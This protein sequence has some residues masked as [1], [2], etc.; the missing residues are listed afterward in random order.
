MLDLGPLPAQERPE[1]ALPPISDRA[2]DPYL[3]RRDFPILQ[4]QVHGRPLVWL[5]NAA[6]TQKP[7][8]VI[9]RLSYFYEHENSNIHR[10]AH[11]LAARSTDAYEAAREKVA[12]LPQRAVRDSIVFVRGTT[13]AINLVARAWGRRNVSEGDEIVITWL[14]HHANIV[15]WQLLCPR[16]ARR[17]A[18]RRSTTAAMISR[19]VREAARPA[20]AL[21]VVHPGLERA[22]HD[23]AGARDGRDG[24]SPR[25]PRAGRRRPGRLATCRSTCRRSA[26]D[27][28]VFSGHKV[29]APTGIGVL[30]GKPEVLEAMP[31]W[32][33]GGNMIED[34]TFE[35]TTYQAPP[36]IRGRHRQHRRCGRPRRRARLLERIGMDNIAA[37]EHEL[38]VYATEGLAHRARSDADRHAPRRRPACSR[39]CSTA[40]APR[41]SARPLTQRASRCARPSLRPADPA[42]LRL[43]GH[44]AAVARPL[45][46][47]RGRRR[48]RRRPAPPAGR[49]GQAG[50]LRPQGACT[51]AGGTLL[52]WAAA[53]AGFC[54]PAI[55]CAIQITQCRTNADREAPGDRPRHGR[56]SAARPSPQC[57]ERQY[58]RA[59]ADDPLH[60]CRWLAGAGRKKL[61]WARARPGSTFAQR[62]VYGRFIAELV[63]PHLGPP[64]EPGP[65]QVAYGEGRGIVVPPLPARASR[66]MTADASQATF[67]CLPPAMTRRRAAVPAC[68]V[69]P[70]QKSSTASGIDPERRVLIRGTGLTIVRFRR[71]TSSRG[72]SRAECTAMSRQQDFCRRRTA[73]SPP[74]RSIRATS[75]SARAS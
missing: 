44:R 18:S 35:K 22:R 51:G 11:T 46:H 13:E 24:A 19:G 67:R 36:D 71:V 66:S 33:G 57:A 10:A 75:R 32:Q 34:V 59:F 49:A 63:A 23:H 6:T 56:G 45:Q 39:S 43:R 1:L 4:E 17:C 73:P 12:P 74:S 38:L 54:S 28:Y 25:R 15:P 55:F 14:E 52:S 9:D 58:E 53:R 29:F 40:S 64:G 20:D 3:F 60:F 41:M 70:R 7:Q 68:Y 50:L 72:T 31:P 30:Y 27:F 5:D 2:F 48:A 62:R 69:N 21:V 47:A 37:Y 42:P 65:L 16:R 8:A 61:T 26:A